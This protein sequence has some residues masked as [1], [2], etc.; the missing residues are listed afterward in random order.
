MHVFEGVAYTKDFLGSATCVI[1]R[2][3]GSVMVTH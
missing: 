1:M 3:E 2:S